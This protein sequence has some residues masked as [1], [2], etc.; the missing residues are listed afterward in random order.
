MELLA[1]LEERFE[2]MNNKIQALEEENR[3]L[4]AELEQERQNKQAVHE[5]IE[6]LLGR[7]QEESV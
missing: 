1:R 3:R 2:E 5:R 7:L 4:C 6:K